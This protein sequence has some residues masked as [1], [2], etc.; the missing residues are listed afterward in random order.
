MRRPFGRSAPW[1]ACTSSTCWAS[2][3]LPAATAPASMVRRSGWYQAV[4]SR[5]FRLPALDAGDDAPRER[6]EVGGARGRARVQHEHVLRGLWAD[7]ED[8]DLVVLRGC[9]RGGVAGDPLEASGG[10]GRCGRSERRHGCED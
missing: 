7:L 9:A 2:F 3:A 4:P 1:M 6:C 5:P 10:G 8:A